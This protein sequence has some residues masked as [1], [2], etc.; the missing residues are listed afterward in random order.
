M[1]GNHGAATVMYP[2]GYAETD[3]ACSDGTSY[4][5]TIPAVTQ[6]FAIPAND[7]TL[8]PS[9]SGSM[10]NP[11]CSN[12]SPGQT[13]GGYFYA[14][15]IQSPGAGNPGM[16]GF[17]TTDGTPATAQTDPLNVTFNLTDSS[18]GQGGAW[19]PATTLNRQNPYSCTPP[20]C[21]VTPT[22]TWPALTN[23]IISGAPLNAT[24]LNATATVTQISGLQGAGSSGLLT[25]TSVPGTFTYTPAA[26][27]V[28]SPGAQT[29]SVTFTPANVGT[30]YTNFT[31]ATASVPILVGTAP[32]TTT[33]VLSKIAG[34]YQIVVT[35]KNTGNVT[36]TNVQLTQA[37]LGA[38]SGA[39]VPASLGDIAGGASAS[40]T[41]TFPSSAGADGAGVVQR[42]TGT[43]TGGTFGGSFRAVLP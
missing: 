31:I 24:Q 11:G 5:L 1:P 6:S 13:T 22:I 8:H 43:Y 23:G 42:L 40:V 2:Y 18:T 3:V 29:L 17:T 7:N 41:L 14:L 10:K 4:T 28:L 12:G 15:G 32:L 36:A 25:T 20:G 38:A 34:G 26:G 39:S 33:G 9:A 30:T 35:V 19:A 16:T 21:P 37:M 27:T